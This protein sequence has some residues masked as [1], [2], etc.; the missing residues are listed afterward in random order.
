LIFDGS[1]YAKAAAFM[2][3][4]ELG[5]KYLAWLH[6]QCCLKENIR[7]LKAYYFSIFFL[8]NEAEEYKA[9]RLPEPSG[10]EPPPPV[11]CEACGEA[12]ARS[13]A[14][15]PFCGLPEYPNPD[16]ISLYRELYKFAPQ[17]REEYFN[18]QTAVFE[19]CG[20]NF[21]K[22]KSSL[23]ALKQEYGLETPS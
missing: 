14:K 11:I 18:K 13:D 7:N 17:K 21:E 9:A 6:E 2:A 20:Y 3:E 1:F 15:C 10:Q 23:A 22:L 12:H 19:E 8:D 16:E 4:R 5:L